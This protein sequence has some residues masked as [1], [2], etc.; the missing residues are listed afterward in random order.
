MTRTCSRFGTRL[1]DCD[2]N[3]STITRRPRRNRRWLS[4][5]STWYSWT[6]EV[7]APYDY[8]PIK[9]H[10]L[11]EINRR[12]DTPRAP[13]R[14]AILSRLLRDI[15]THR[16]PSIAICCCKQL[17]KCCHQRA[18]PRPSS[19]P[20]MSRSNNRAIAVTP[21]VF[22]FFFFFYRGN[23]RQRFTVEIDTVKV[24]ARELHA[25]TRATIRGWPQVEPRSRRLISVCAHATC[26]RVCTRTRRRGAKRACHVRRCDVYTTTT[27][28]A[29]PR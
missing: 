15:R 5:T 29:T 13:S 8:A 18:L 21:G 3:G 11:M 9:R 26:I 17:S 19:F 10:L 20:E 2:A 1:S 27:R 4:R 23:A 6:S 7:R 12:R 16:P 25:K 22:T 28:D 24:I 14:A